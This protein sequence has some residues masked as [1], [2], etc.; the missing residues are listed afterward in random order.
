[1]HEVWLVE[2]SARKTLLQLIVKPTY[3]SAVLGRGGAAAATDITKADH[4]VGTALAKVPLLCA[5]EV[6]RHRIIH[7]VCMHTTWGWQTDAQ[8]SLDTNGYTGAQ[9]VTTS[10]S[11]TAEGIGSRSWAHTCVSCGGGAATTT[12]VAE[13]LHETCAALAKCLLLGTCVVVRGRVIRAGTCS[14]AQRVSWVDTMGKQLCKCI[15]KPGCR[16]LTFSIAP[17]AAQVAKALHEGFGTQAQR[18]LLLAGE[19][20]RWRH[21]ATGACSSRRCAVTG[22]SIFMATLQQVLRLLLPV[23]ASLVDGSG[24]AVSHLAGYSAAAGAPR[25]DVSHFAEPGRWSL[26][27]K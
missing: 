14:R 16:L 17:P 6:A 1:M 4:E 7:T 18:Q 11:T 22:T 27:C 19:L 12:L 23:H 13:A 21:I 15:P 5:G 8:S 2:Q 3:T 9:S 24:Q 10:N 20:R 26:T 25:L